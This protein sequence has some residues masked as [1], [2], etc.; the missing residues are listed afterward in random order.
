MALM[1]SLDVLKINNSEELIGLIDDVVQEIPELQFFGASPV[2]KN[3]YKTLALTGLPST[4]FR[5]TGTLRE[6]QTVTLENRTVTC[7]YL[8]ASWTLEQAV[9]QQSDWGEDFAKTL[10]ARAHLKSAF[11]TLAKQIWHGVNNDAYGFVGLDAFISAVVDSD[12]NEIMTV[13]ANQSAQTLGTTV[14][15]VRTGID[16]CQLAWGSEGKFDEG[17]VVEQLL[18]E[19]STTTEGEGASAVT[20]LHTSGAWHYAQKLGGWVGL[21][22]TS[23]YAAARITNLDVS[24]TNAGLD[25]DLLYQLIEKFPV[26]MKPNGIFMSRGSLAQLRQSRTAYNAVGLPAPYPTDFEGIPIYVTDAIGNVAST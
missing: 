3:T 13:K 18:Y 23:K 10:Q 20:T 14:Y 21:Q 6:F 1:T 19:R 24:G 12:S 7:K 25:D 4:G 26:G 16:S 2:A 5:E 15:A 8:D 22:T 11:Y 9:A 17:D